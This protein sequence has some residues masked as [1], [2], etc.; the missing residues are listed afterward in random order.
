MSD[1]KG[2]IPRDVRTVLFW[3]LG[4]GMLALM[5]LIMAIIFGNLSG[6]LG[7]DSDT[8]TIT[9]ANETTSSAVGLWLNLTTYTLSG[10]NST[11]GSI[12]VVGVY[13]FSDASGLNSSQYSLSS[14]GVIQNG[15]NTEYANVSMD[16]T[17]VH[18]FQGQ[19]EKGVEAI[20]GNYTESA[21][22][23]SKQFPVTGTILGIA[24]LLT[25][26]IGILVFAIKKMMGV[27]GAGNSKES[28]GSSSGGFDRA[29]FG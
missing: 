2:G 15:T 24:L 29:S 20:I 12:T 8:T 28:L 26:L 25:I 16:Y 22:N 14:V 9:V 10:Y 21:V 5:L 1:N 6:N 23:T 19:S 7:F 17:Y 18:S 4:I 3:G 27:A 13:N 11:W